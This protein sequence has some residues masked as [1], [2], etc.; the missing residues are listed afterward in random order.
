MG[1]LG[2]VDGIR[3]RGIYKFQKNSH[4]DLYGFAGLAYSSKATGWN[5][6]VTDKVDITTTGAELGAGIEF[7]LRNM[8][9]LPLYLSIEAGYRASST[10]VDKKITVN[11]KYGNGSAKGSASYDYSGAIGGVWIH[12]EF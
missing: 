10:D 3:L 7:D 9:N 6:T 8:T 12:Y 4:Y 1:G 2:D 11:G 5:T